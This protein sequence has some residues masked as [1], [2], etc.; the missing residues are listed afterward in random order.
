[1]NLDELIVLSA[2]Q[3]HAGQPDQS[4]VTCQQILMQEVNHVTAW[5]NASAALAAMGRWIDALAYARY[6][7]ALE[8]QRPDALNNCAE[9]LLALGRK[10]EAALLFRNLG[11]TQYQAKERDAAMASY[12]RALS[13]NPQDV[14]CLHVLA[15]LHS[16]RKESTQAL[17]LM[18]RVLG[19]NPQHLATLAAKGNLL[20]GQAEQGLAAEACFQTALTIDPNHWMTLYNYGVYL[21]NVERYSEAVQMYVRA[22]HADPNHHLSFWNLSNLLLRLGDY[23]HAWPLYEWRWKTDHLK[24]AYLQLPMPLWLGQNLQGKRI[25]LHFEQGYGDAF[26]FIRF[27]KDVA[28]RGAHVTIFMPKEICDNFVGVAG[29]HEIKPWHE[30]PQGFDYHAPLMSLPVPLGLTM[31]NIPSQAPYMLANPE[32]IRLWQERLLKLGKSK[33]QK[34]RVGLA[35]CGRPTHENDR[36]RS[37]AFDELVPLIDAFPQAQ[38]VSL[39][40][41]PRESDLPALDA[42]QAIVR[43]EDQIK[44]FSDTA[45]LIMQLDV[46]I[47]VD[48]SVVHLAGAL[49]KPVWAMIPAASDWRWLLNVEPYAEATPWYPNVRLFRQSLDDGKTWR[50]TNVLARVQ[51]ELEK[52]LLSQQATQHSSKVA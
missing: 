49:G 35:W 29:V 51:S 30:I 18:N 19:I 12:E 33:K 24:P 34:L 10:E 45:A 46:L 47:S 42:C 48:T 38:F 8:P 26:Q 13:M 7:L 11:W 4:L 31:Q 2:Q 16:E 32:R 52:L 23:P 37:I 43:I 40:V 14:E 22:G 15:G 25:L 3:Y 39:Q 44:D 50:W 6:A 27:A 9:I 28:A 21:A 41:G 17:M 20:G 1:M 36:N 5:S